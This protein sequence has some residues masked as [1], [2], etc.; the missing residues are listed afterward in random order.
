MG[1]NTVTDILERLKTA[2]ADRYV[3]E[4]EIGAGGMATVYLAEDLKHH[5][6][7]A[8]K[9]LR[10]ELAA[11]L[12]PER[13]LR[14]IEVAAQLHHPHILPLYDSGE[15]DGFLYYV[16]PYEQGQSL[17][18]KLVK[19]GELPV[20]EAVRVLRDVVD[21]LAHAHEEGVVHRDIKPENI[22]LSGR[23]ALVTDFG[24][25]KAISEATGREKLTTAGVALGTPSYMAPEQAS[26]DPH[27]DHRADIYA[28]GVMAYELL[29]GRVPFGGPTAQ[30]ILS[31]HITETP[32]PVTKHR[33]AVSPALAQL[34]M[35]CLEKKPA[36]RWQSAEELLSHI[37]AAATPSGGIAP[38]DTQPVAT[39]FIRRQPRAVKIA[40]GVAAALVLIITGWMFRGS[41]SDV[42]QRSIAVLPLS[43]VDVVS[44]SITAGIHDDIITQLGRIGALTVISRNSVLE[45]TDTPKSTRQIGQELGVATL[46]TG[47]V[48]RA[49]DQ[50]RINVQ[51]IDAVS[52][53]VLW[54]DA[55][56]RQWTIETRFEI[57]ADIAEQIAGSLEAALTQKER[58]RIGELPTTNDEAYELYLTGN[59]Y[60]D[61]SSTE[62][63]TRISLQQYE[64]AVELDPNFAAAHARLSTSHSRMWWYAYDR[65]EERLTRARRA[66]DETFRLD[67]DLPEAH[68]AR[69]YYYYWGFLDYD[70]AIAAFEIARAARPNDAQLLLGLGSVYRRQGKLDEAL[71]AILRAAQLDP[72]STELALNVAQSYALMR[73]ATEADQYYDQAISLT[74]DWALAYS[75][76]AT[77]TSLRLQG[78]VDKARASLD[79]ASATG[80]DD[81]H[82]IVAARTLVD[83]A[84]GEYEAALS[85]LLAFPAPDLRH[86]PQFQYVPTAQRLAEIYHLMGNETSATAY[87]DSARIHMETKLAEL[88]EDERYHSALGIAYAGLGQ[89]EDAIREGLRGTE[90]MPVDKEAWRGAHRVE[91]LAQ[92]Y[93]MVGE[94]DLAMEQIERLLS[95][96]YYFTAKTLEVFPTWASLKDH[97]RYQQLIAAN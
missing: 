54:S 44:E 12:G 32:E 3:I 64:Q 61:R 20:T 84:G 28:V 4:R 35:R 65:T 55:Y 95:L 96:P 15:A 67:P 39:P 22:M 76:K 74:P 47:G 97:P 66:L 26:G 91:D 31:A 42:D 24:V 80:L 29:A 43:S 89:K 49:G 36:D 93:T 63:D 69:G 1:Q 14:E 11:T 13:F 72:R 77:I 34:V 46:L 6:Q 50:V 82:E 71:A 7:V 78:D 52:D 9:V 40:G 18:E 45:Y 51:L 94:Y 83:M 2:L 85:R 38:T 68:R 60:Y 75:Y 25:A 73:Q 37:E 56:N 41:G 53:K 5:R 21:A 58:A 79:P 70:R 16:M 81:E 19:E 17:R 88:P 30:A 23:H 27:I 90:L 92:I 57:Q 10:P 62:R 8:V 59:R 33:Q 86:M 87:Y 48:Q